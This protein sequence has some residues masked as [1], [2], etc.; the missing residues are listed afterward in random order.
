MK[1]YLLIFWESGDIELTG[2]YVTDE[3][4]DQALKGAHI[5]RA[6]TVCRLNITDHGEPEIEPYTDAEIDE[7]VGDDD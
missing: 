6:N 2:D 3:E 4:R 7:I 1:R 5:H